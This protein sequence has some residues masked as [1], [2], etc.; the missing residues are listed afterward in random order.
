MMMIFG[1]IRYQPISGILWWQL[2]SEGYV[3]SSKI[4]VIGDYQYGGR[5]IL[6]VN[7]EELSS[8][9]K[10]GQ[11]RQM[12]SSNSFHLFGPNLLFLDKKLGHIISYNHRTFS[13]GTPYIFK[14]SRFTFLKAFSFSEG[15]Q[16]WFCTKMNIYHVFCWI[17]PFSLI[18]LS[19][20][21]VLCEKS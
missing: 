1:P 5:S 14:L 7:R 20:A 13:D 15:T 4:M 9:C 16:F 18:Y 17:S 10:C 2:K 21:C 8:H 3:H 19:V 6:W 12:L 11:R